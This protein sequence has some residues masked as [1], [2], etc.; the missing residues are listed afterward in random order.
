MPNDEARTRANPLYLLADWGLIRSFG[1][2][3]SSVIGHS[4][5]VISSL[6][7]RQRPFSR[8]V[9]DLVAGQPAP[10]GLDGEDGR[11][12]GRVPSTACPGASLSPQA[13]GLSFEKVRAML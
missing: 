6:G 11:K 2:C 8:F 4:A 9:P 7:F 12:P 3:H 1:F 13:Q 5:F 10:G